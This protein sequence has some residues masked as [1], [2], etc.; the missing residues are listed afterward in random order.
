MW[1]YSITVGEQN[2]ETSKWKI[3]LMVLKTSVNECNI[4]HYIWQS[5]GKSEICKQAKSVNGPK[6][7]FI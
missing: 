3:I 7:G 5:V 1:Y 2:K 6:T 4:L